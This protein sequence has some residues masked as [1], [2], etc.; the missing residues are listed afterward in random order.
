MAPGIQDHSLLDLHTDSVLRA[1]WDG[2]DVDHKAVGGHLPLG[3]RNSTPVG[4]SSLLT[5]Q[6]AH[7]LLQ[8]HQQQQ[9]QQQQQQA[10]MAQ[11]SSPMETPLHR[12][13]E[14]TQ[15]EPVKGGDRQANSSRYKTELCRPFE[16]NGYCKYGDKCQF[17]HG[18][19]DLR[20][21]TRHPKYKT[22]LCRTF[23]TIGFCPYGPR[24]HFIHNAE[25]RRGPEPA[26]PTKQAL[27][28]P[29]GF[30]ASHQHFNSPAFNSM[31]QNSL[32]GNS[33]SSFNQGSINTN[34]LNQSAL[35]NAFSNQS[36]NG[37]PLL[38]RPQ[39]LQVGTGLSAF[40]SATESSS[41]LS[42][43]GS[44]FGSSGESPSPPSS[45]HGSPTSSAGSFFDDAFSL[46]PGG[47]GLN[48]GKGFLDSLSIGLGTHGLAAASGALHSPGGSSIDGRALSE[49]DLI[50]EGGLLSLAGLDTPPLTPVE[51]LA[52][53]LD[54]LSISSS[55]SASP[56][57]ATSGD[58]S[59]NNR[60][61]IFETLSEH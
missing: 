3:K 4:H 14:R 52:G 54:N 2:R 1:T 8:H 16:E 28:L 48:N 13:L 42:P 23:H 30:Q 61:R 10:K 33:L 50:R 22:E 19:Q 31:A 35:S 40:G 49:M 55:H 59:R 39:A 27:H 20:T 21:L 47:C 43:F 58:N 18:G 12:R 24:C 17:A 56:T 51:S 34:F 9:Q 60:L 36:N 25:E 15:S 6:A 57:P 32:S 41:G 26:V 53:D 45:I 46:F 29:P 37:H 38:S 44:S 11:Q 5:P 7:S